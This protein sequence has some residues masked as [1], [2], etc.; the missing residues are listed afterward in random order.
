LEGPVAERIVAYAD[1]RDTDLI[2]LSSH[3][4]GGLSEWNVSHIA[5]KVLQRGITSIFLV[6]A[7]F[8]GYGSAEQIDYHRVLLPLDGSRR[9]ECV[10]PV[11]RM[12]AERGQSELLLAHVTARP[13]LF[14]RTPPTEAETAAQDWL[15]NHNRDGAGDYLRQLASRLTSKIRI[16]LPVDDNVALALHR[17]VADEA[18]QLVLLSA[19]G[20]TAQSQWP[21]GSITGNFIANGSVPL[22]IVQDLP[23]PLSQQPQIKNARRQLLHS[24]PKGASY[25]SKA[26]A[27]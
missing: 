25:F 27:E 12:L 22:L 4:Q 21:Y 23:Q 18:V 15:I 6:P 19:H 13:A 5:Q 2:I 17:L 3:G 26:F 7:E 16:A 1:Q 11:A 10:L 20:R 14:G 9:A 8:A 24:S